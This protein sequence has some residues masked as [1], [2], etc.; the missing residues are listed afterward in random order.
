MHYNTQKPVIH[1]I[2]VQFFVFCSIQQILNYGALNKI[3]LD[4]QSQNLI[5]L[6]FSL[7]SQML[8]LI[9]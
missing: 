1:E 9:H 2:L 3:T 7:N 4:I 8:T 5:Y 6:N